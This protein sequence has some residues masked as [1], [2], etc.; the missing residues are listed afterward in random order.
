MVMNLNHM[1]KCFSKRTNETSYENVLVIVPGAE[2]ENQSC[3]GVGYKPTKRIL[4]WGTKLCE[5][6]SVILVGTVEAEPAI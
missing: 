1:L 6:H 5:I 4:L 3:E 2:N